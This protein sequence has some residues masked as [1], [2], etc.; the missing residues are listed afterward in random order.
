MVAK[1]IDVCLFNW[2]RIGKW[3]VFFLRTESLSLFFV[4]FVPNR[5]SSVSFQGMCPWSL[6]QRLWGKE[7]AFVTTKFL[8]FDS[9][10][11]FWRQEITA[12]KKSMRWALIGLT[13]LEKL[14][15]WLAFVW[16]IVSVSWQGGIAFLRASLCGGEVAGMFWLNR[17]Q[18]KGYKRGWRTHTKRCALVVLMLREQ[19]YLSKHVQADFGRHSHFLLLA[20]VVL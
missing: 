17:I 13:V 11:A 3:I 7:L 2:I 15:S 10:R 18:S 8:I 12:G 6:R 20:F 19:Q 4:L 1:S 9:L 16:A 14:V 5:L